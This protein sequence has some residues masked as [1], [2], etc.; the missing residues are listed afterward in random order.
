MVGDGDLQMS[1]ELRLDV[2]CCLV[3]AVLLGVRVAGLE[4]CA[5]L[6]PR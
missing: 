2:M 4:V 1:V 6:P 3:V 5:T